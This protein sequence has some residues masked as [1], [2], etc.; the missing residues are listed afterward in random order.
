MFTTLAEVAIEDFDQFLHVFSDAGF[1]ARRRHG[2]LGAEAFRVAE[3]AKAA[4]VLIDWQ[5]RE[6]FD[7]F[8]A[9]L[10]VKATMRS[11]GATRPPKFTF[12]ERAGRFDA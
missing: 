10:E 9:D 6:S 2:S 3:D 12:I 7:G 4:V 1:Q 8:V 5:D 11:G